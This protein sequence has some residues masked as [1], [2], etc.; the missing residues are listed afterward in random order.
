MLLNLRSGRILNFVL[1]LSFLTASSASAQLFE[2][3][4]SGQS[5]VSSMSS[6]AAYDPVHDRYLVVTGF[7]TVIGQFFDRFGNAAGSSFSLDIG[8][9]L[10]VLRVVY[11]PHVSNGAGGF[12]GFVVIWSYDHGQ[13][14]FAQIVSLPSGLVG[15]RRTIFTGPPSTFVVSADLAYAQ[16]DRVFLVALTYFAATANQPSQMVRL[17]LQAQSIGQTSL[18]FDPNQ[19]CINEEFFWTCNIHVAWN[20][21]SREFGVLYRQGVSLGAPIQKTLARVRADGAIVGRTAIADLDNQFSAFAVNA[22]TGN[23]LL[24]AGSSISTVRGVELAPDG[25]VMAKGLVTSALQTDGSQ[26]QPLAL[27]YSPASGTFLLAG[28][29]ATPFSITGT[30]LQLN[31]HGVALSST[32]TVSSF[33]FGV[34]AHETSSEWVVSV[35][36]GTSIIGT[37]AP[38]GGSNALL[39]DC[40]TPDPFTSLGGGRC[41]NRGWLPPGHPLIPPGTPAPPA[42]PPPPSGGCTI[43]DPFTSLG[44]GVCVNGGWVPRGHPLAGGG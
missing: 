16:T 3:A 25:S 22:A 12:G 37:T 38:F 24:L 8:S 2:I 42:P 39:P 4:R 7:P 6:H 23:Y 9:A 35:R 36:E 17:D 29:T 1:S 27:S 33:W 5:P 18:S 41:V 40:L 13:N 34:A 14:V 31:Q 26:L 10:F 11:S 19:S 44:G 15:A 21:I 30:L 28:H 43:P 32:Q 20:P